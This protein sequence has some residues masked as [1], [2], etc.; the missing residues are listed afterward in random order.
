MSD[1]FT[2][3]KDN[4]EVISVIVIVSGGIG[5]LLNYFLA[6]K[7]INEDRKSVRQQMITNNIAP[8]RQ[9]WINDLRKTSSEFISDVNVIYSYY[10][11]KADGVKNPIMSDK[12]D[13]ITLSATIKISYLDLLLPFKNENREEI[14][15]E[16]VREDIFKLY[17]YASN[18][19]EKQSEDK[20]EN[21]NKGSKDD[22][23]TDEFTN[24]IEALRKSLKILLKKEWEVTKSLSEIDCGDDINDKYIKHIIESKYK[25]NSDNKW[26]QY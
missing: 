16:K 17:N 25:C 5:F 1:F 11:D 22:N 3:I 4:K 10:I 6:R 19:E 9:Q 18:K 20:G 26:F 24:T 8:M 7:K 12:I 15:A 14:E 21:S 2:L 23:E 13:D